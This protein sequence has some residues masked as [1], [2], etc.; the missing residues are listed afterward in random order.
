MRILRNTV[1]RVVLV[2]VVTVTVIIFLLA[3]VIS[4][5]FLHLLSSKVAILVSTICTNVAFSDCHQFLSFGLAEQL[6]A[7]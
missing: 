1:D 2:L 7:A 4:G 6:E 5:N 3:L